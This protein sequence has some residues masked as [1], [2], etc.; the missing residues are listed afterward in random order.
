MNQLSMRKVEG[1]KRY[2]LI[3]IPE[4]MPV[5]LSKELF[6]NYLK[7]VKEGGKLLCL[8]TKWTIGRDDLTRLKDV[9]WRDPICQIPCS[10][11]KLND[12][13]SDKSRREYSNS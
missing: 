13:T 8:N 4:G 10:G 11:N 9:T 1:L 5:G 3:I 6:N 7:Y 2:K 12:R